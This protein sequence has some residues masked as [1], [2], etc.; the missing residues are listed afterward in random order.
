MG[1]PAY[2]A[3]VAAGQLV[4]VMAGARA[5]AEYELLLGIRG[6]GLAMQDAYT[7]SMLLL[8]ALIIIGNTKGRWKK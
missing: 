1:A 3:Y 5:A 2:M 6:P 4:T 7:L 8:L